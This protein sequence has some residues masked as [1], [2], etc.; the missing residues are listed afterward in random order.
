MSSHPLGPCGLAIGKSL[1][2]DA[3]AI[4]GVD[5]SRSG[6]SLDDETLP[7]IPDSF[8]DGSAP[9]LRV[10]DLK[11]ILFPGF[12]KLLS[13]ATHLV[14]LRLRNIPHSVYVS[15][16]AM[17]AL[18]S[19]LS[20]LEALELEFES[21]Q[22]RPDWEPRHPPPSKRTVIPALDYFRFKG[23]IEYLEDLV[24]FIDAPQLNFLHITSFNEIDFD[25]PRL[26]QFI[27]CT[28]TLR[29][30]DEAH[31]QFNDRAA[32][33][34]LRYRTSKSTS[35]SYNLEIAIPC[36]GPDWQLSSVAQVCN[37]S[38]PPLSMVEGL[39]IEHK[40]WRL[41]WKN[42]AIKS[43]LRLRLEVL[44][45]FTVVKNLY[46]SNAFAPDIAAALQELIGARITEVLPSLQNIFVEGLRAERL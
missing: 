30:L 20:S 4:P 6:A 44:L 21:P 24:T 1:G 11:G 12:P 34:K 43:T 9:R 5:R 27:N 19:V 22:S 14:Y 10:F 37:S 32:S 35:S 26:A 13:S 2:C 15:P 29:A 8:L 28:P 41:D 25:N 16:E 18:L 23:I 36:R 31:V 3:G 45:P 38:L 33:V 40:Y 7:V 46:L 17:V 42:D 39:Y